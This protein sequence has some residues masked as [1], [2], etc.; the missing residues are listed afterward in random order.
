MLVLQTIIR[1]LLAVAEFCQKGVVVEVGL[2]SSRERGRRKRVQEF[3]STRVRNLRDRRKKN[4]TAVAPSVENSTVR[5][6]DSD[7]LQRGRKCWCP[8]ERSGY[9]KRSEQ[10]PCRDRTASQPGSSR[11]TPL[12]S[13]D[14]GQWVGCRAARRF[15]AECAGDQ[16]S[17]VNQRLV[18]QPSVASSNP[19]MGQCRKFSVPSSSRLAA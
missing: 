8:P 6:F 19:H 10:N 15:A 3:C 18:A 12:D 14:R 5:Q 9:R 17:V 1:I 11:H 13:S 16:L 4:P 2:T 7:V